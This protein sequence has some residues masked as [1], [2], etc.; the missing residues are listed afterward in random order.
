MLWSLLVLLVPTLTFGAGNSI[1]CKETLECPY[2]MIRMISYGNTAYSGDPFYVSASVYDCCNVSYEWGYDLQ[3]CIISGPASFDS[4]VY[5]QCTTIT[6][7]HYYY[8]TLYYNTASGNITNSSE[9]ILL[10]QTQWPI[11]ETLQSNISVMLNPP[12]QHMHQHFCYNDS[13]KGPCAPGYGVPINQLN[14][15]VQCDQYPLPDWIIFI[16]IQ[17]LPVTVVVL[18]IIV[19]NIQLTNGFMNGLIF[20]SQMISIVYPNL[21]LN[22]AFHIYYGSYYYIYCSPYCPSA[23]V[24]P[25]NLFNLNFVMFFVKPLCITSNMTLLQAILFWYIIPTYPLVLLLLIYTWIIMYDKGFR[26]VVTI[27]RP[28]HRLLARFWRMTKIEPSLIHSIA[29]IYLLCFTQ[30]AATSFQLL[31]PTTRYYKNESGIA[32]Y[33]GTLKYFGWPH[34]FAGIF[35]IIVL[36][37]IIFLPMLYIQLYPFKLFHKLL[38]HLH[39]RKEILISLSDVFTGPY[40]DGSKNTRDYRYFAG[41]YLFLRIIILCL[42]FEPK[43]AKHIFFPQLALFSV[44]GGTI[45]IFR[46]YK[47]N[48]HSFFDLFFLLLFT[49]VTVVRYAYIINLLLLV[50]FLGIIIYWTIKICYRSCKTNRK[51]NTPNNEEHEDMEY[52]LVDD[53]NWNVDRMEHPDDYDEHHVQYVPYD[54]T[55]S[56][57]EENTVHATYDNTRSAEINN[58]EIGSPSESDTWSILGSSNTIPLH[59][60]VST[61]QEGNISNVDD[62]DGMLIV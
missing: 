46:P 56:Q 33:D 15:C 9:V 41:F 47:R 59:S 23:F 7:D 38:S 18:I 22:I 3:A 24:I 4:N 20:Y 26:C 5:Q 35:A 10:I 21:S 12:I 30:F 40:K 60:I 37:F 16:L 34:G 25:G 57:P 29:S 62:E 14:K 13:R 49:I 42:Y 58:F 8:I 48:I 45:A 36:V 19:F 50:I 31:Y 6:Y 17:L 2:L 55:V 1:D 61:T 32:F 28:L 51:H 54:L 44:F 52:I 27:T 43:D 39:L 11:I 53:D